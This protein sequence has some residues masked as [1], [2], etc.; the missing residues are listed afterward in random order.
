MKTFLADASVVIGRSP[1]PR[2]AAGHD[3]TESGAGW[4]SGTATRRLVL[5]S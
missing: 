5:M 4:S 2:L 3:V 1:V